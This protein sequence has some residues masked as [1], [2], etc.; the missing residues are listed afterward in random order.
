MLLYLSTSFCLNVSENETTA[1]INYNHVQSQ[2]PQPV[3]LVTSASDPYQVGSSPMAIVVS[4]EP[5]LAPSVKSST[6]TVHKSNEAVIQSEMLSTRT[7]IT[8]YSTHT[9]QRIFS[10]LKGKLQDTIVLFRLRGF[11]CFLGYIIMNRATQS[12]V[13]IAPN[14]ALAVI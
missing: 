9:N 13:F 8:L 11:I 5:C 12:F 7:S 10:F 1:I 6:S 14:K 4:S 2:R 3:V